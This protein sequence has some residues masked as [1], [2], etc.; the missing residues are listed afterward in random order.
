M[1]TSLGAGEQK[2]TR[3]QNNFATIVIKIL[4]SKNL[5]QRARALISFDVQNCTK[6]VST[7]SSIKVP[8]RQNEANELTSSVEEDM[9][10]MKDKSPRKLSVAFCDE[11]QVHMIPVLEEMTS[12]ELESIWFSKSEFSKLHS[13]HDKLVRKVSR[14]EPINEKKECTAGLS[15]FG[16]SGS[17]LTM[18][19]RSDGLRA[20]FRVQKA[21]KEQGIYDPDSIARAYGEVASWSQLDASIV[22]VQA[23]TEARACYEDE[24]DE[25]SER[26]RSLFFKPRKSNSTAQI[27]S[28]TKLPVVR[29]GKRK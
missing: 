18:Q 3:L 19:R 15:R 20:V 22:A 23:E 11:D 8:C 29:F 12:E 27:N 28:R 13:D 5:V 2:A 4:A 26:T 24:D 7:N 9:K 10:R 21:Q 17:R 16:E 14:G 6:M 1:H 25:R